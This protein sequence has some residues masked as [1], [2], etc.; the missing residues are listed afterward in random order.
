MSSSTNSDVLA[1]EKVKIFFSKLHHEQI[2]DCIAQSFIP[3]I[4]VT[5]STANTSLIQVKSGFSFVCH[6]SQNTDFILSIYL[7]ITLCQLGEAR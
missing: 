5:E 1:L 2:R 4:F 7:Y 6:M 3:A